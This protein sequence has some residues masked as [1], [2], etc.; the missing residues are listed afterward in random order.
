M[1]FRSGNIRELAEVLDGAAKLAGTGPI[2]REHL[3]HELRVRAGLPS[4]A[5]RDANLQR[6]P[7]LHE[8]ERRLILTA[9]R[10]TGQNTKRAAEL[11]G[12]S[13]AELVRRAKSLKIELPS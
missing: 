12:I 3:P 6:D 9:L 10:R 2:T 8:V 4:S 11:L 13:R 7:L 5:N 1:L